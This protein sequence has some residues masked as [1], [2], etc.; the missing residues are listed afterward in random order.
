M[1][2][3]PEYI[4][5]VNSIF[6]SGYIQSNTGLGNKTTALH[7]TNKKVAQAHG[8]LLAAVLRTK[9]GHVK[10]DASYKVTKV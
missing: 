5:Y 7:F 9:S 10:I 6:M 4:V 1:P 2:K 8:S 3:I